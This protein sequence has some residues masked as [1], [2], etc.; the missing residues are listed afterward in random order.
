MSGV[1][2][3]SGW[4]WR[5][6]HPRCSRVT[7]YI[8]QSQPQP[9]EERPSCRHVTGV[10]PTR[11]RGP[12]PSCR[13]ALLAADAPHVFWAPRGARP[14]RGAVVAVPADEAHPVVPAPRP[15]LCN[16]CYAPGPRPQ[17]PTHGRP[18]GHVRASRTTSN[19]AVLIHSRQPK[20]LKK[21]KY[22]ESL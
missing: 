21:E 22:L 16:V 18:K 2:P 11:S 14:T 5:P 13:A 10:S 8:V 4:A 20:N 6:R 7:V 3:A 15:H 1:L 19:W 17:G 9:G 12:R